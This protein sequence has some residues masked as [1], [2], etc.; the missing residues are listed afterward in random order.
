MCAQEGPAYE[1]EQAEA[2]EPE[3]EVYEE[4]PAAAEVQAESHV[5]NA[6]H[7]FLELLPAAD[8]DGAGQIGQEEADNLP[9]PARARTCSVA[10]SKEGGRVWVGCV[11]DSAHCVNTSQR[12]SRKKFPRKI[13]LLRSL[14]Q[15]LRP[16]PNRKRRRNKP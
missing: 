9:S 10:L 14:S 6:V 16:N 1:E 11:W 7:L 12:N 5:R 13:M 3:E 8:V 4:E 15:S 2:A